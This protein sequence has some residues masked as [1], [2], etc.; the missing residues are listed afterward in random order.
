MYGNIA[1]FV[2]L[3]KTP[4][5][6]IIYSLRLDGQVWSWGKSARGRLGRETVENHIPAPVQLDYKDPYSVV[7]LS[8]SHGTTLLAIKRM[9]YLYI[10]RYITFSMANSVQ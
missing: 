6:Y 8:S 9:S 7:S 4:N 1:N 10:H 5:N 3:W 2:H